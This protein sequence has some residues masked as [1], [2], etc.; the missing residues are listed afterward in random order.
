MRVV[1][2]VESMVSTM[3]ELFKRL[4]EAFSRGDTNEINRVN[5]EIYKNLGQTVVNSTIDYDFINNI[6][7]KAVHKNLCKVV[8]DEDISLNEMSKLLSSLVTHII[9]ECKDSNDY[10]SYPL[11]VLLNT[12]EELTLGGGDGVDDARKFIK[13][14]YSRYL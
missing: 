10:R 4:D 2:E 12:L 9:I 13:E 7:G 5:D 3:D 8:N 1:G 6:K 11:K 14:R